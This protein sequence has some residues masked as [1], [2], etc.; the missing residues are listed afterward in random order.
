M[1]ITKQKKYNHYLQYTIYNIT[2]YYNYILKKYGYNN[3]H[4]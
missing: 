3:I 2:I 1:E 4:G